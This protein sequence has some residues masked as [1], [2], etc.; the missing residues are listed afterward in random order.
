MLFNLLSKVPVV[1]GFFSPTEK[2]RIAGGGAASSGS[3]ASQKAQQDASP[4]GVEEGVE[5]PADVA[6]EQAQIHAR[7]ATMIAQDSGPVVKCVVLRASGAAEEV[8]IDMAPKLGEI[9]ATLGGAVCFVGQYEPIEVMVV[10]RQPEPIAALPK[11]TH[12]LPVPHELEEVHGDMLLFRSDQD[13]EPIDFTLAEYEAFRAQKPAAWQ[14]E[15]VKA[16]EEEEEE[17]DDDDDED[18]SESDS[19][20]DDAGDKPEAADGDEEEDDDDAYDSDDAAAEDEAEGAS[21]PA[22][23]CAFFLERACGAFETKHG[24]APD[25]DE[26]AALARAV[27]VKLGLVLPSFSEEADDEDDE[28]ALSPEEEQRAEQIVLTKVTNRNES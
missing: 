20:D 21:D 18:D 14:L 3:A 11:S 16:R 1:G 9:S 25:D 4:A 13:S 5:A 8:D 23:D 15:C 22:A 12:V 24:R 26:R 2:E 17:E 6:A 19:D 10:R 28:D 27:G 7:I